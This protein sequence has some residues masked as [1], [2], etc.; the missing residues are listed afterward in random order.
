MQKRDTSKD[1]TKFSDA[2]PNQRL[3][4]IGILLLIGG[5][6]TYGVLNNSSKDT[7]SVVSTPNQPQSTNT[8]ELKKEE[9][10]TIQ[11]SE[12]VDITHDTVYAHAYYFCMQKGKDRSDIEL[13]EKTA[14]CAC[15]GMR[16]EKNSQ[17][18]QNDV[19][20]WVPTEAQT[21]VCAQAIADGHNGVGLYEEVEASQEDMQ[22]EAEQ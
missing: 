21:V 22:E 15:Y 4:G 17:E 16:A 8:A 10:P 20:R 14:F 19:S 6:I 12:V 5:S 7:V 3:F 1:F 13:K 18:N 11:P 2:T 9:A